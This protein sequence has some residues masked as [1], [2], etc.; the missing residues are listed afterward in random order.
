MGKAIWYK[1]VDGKSITQSALFV[2]DLNNFSNLTNNQFNITHSY[3]SNRFSGGGFLKVV[4]A[5]ST[6]LIFDFLFY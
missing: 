6:R 1:N 4:E 2:I 3:R 5:G